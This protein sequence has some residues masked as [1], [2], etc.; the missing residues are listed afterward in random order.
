MDWRNEGERSRREDRRI[1][2]HR[3]LTVIPSMLLDKREASKDID[4]RRYFIAIVSERLA[5]PQRV[6][7]RSDPSLIAMVHEHTRFLLFEAVIASLASCE[8]LEKL[9]H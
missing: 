4:S 8:S 5:N 7:G 3:G 1:S 2:S 6:T 9:G